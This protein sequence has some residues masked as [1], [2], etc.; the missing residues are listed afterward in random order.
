MSD[1][2]KI[3]KNDTEKVKKKTLKKVK[4]ELDD[5]V[6]VEKRPLEGLAKEIFDMLGELDN[7]TEKVKTILEVL[8]HDQSLFEAIMGRYVFEVEQAIRM[9]FAVD[10]TKDKDDVIFWNMGRSLSMVSKMMME[11]HFP[12]ELLAFQR[13]I[14]KLKKKYKKDE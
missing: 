3:K 7:E 11:K 5:G 1:S 10:N 8:A 4:E 12:D 13:R 14:V 9:T 6:W 2:E